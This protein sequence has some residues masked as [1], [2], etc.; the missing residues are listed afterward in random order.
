MTRRLDRAEQ[1]ARSIGPDRD[2]VTAA[3]ARLV[4]EAAALARGEPLDH[5]QAAAAIVRADARRR[6]IDLDNPEV[7]AA[8][9]AEVVDA[10]AP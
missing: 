7:V 9:R 5:D 10:L 6:G 4:A 3:R 8:L 1:A 2:A